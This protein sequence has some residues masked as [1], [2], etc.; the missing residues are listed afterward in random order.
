VFF[1]E[2]LLDKTQW[3]WLAF[4]GCP[5]KKQ[6]HSVGDDDDDDDDDDVCVCVCVLCVCVCVCV[7]LCVC[8]CERARSGMNRERK[9]MHDCL[10]G[11][12]FVVQ[13][14]MFRA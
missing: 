3:L 8:V 7:C 12:V 11:L 14:G 10:T 9:R 6:F 4:G 1:A 5:L 2:V 13:R